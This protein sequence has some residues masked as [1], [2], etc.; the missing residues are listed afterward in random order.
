MA[1]SAGQGQSF[2]LTSFRATR[3]TLALTLESGDISHGAGTRIEH[4]EGGFT[5]SFRA[6][7]GGLTT[8]PRPLTPQE[9]GDLRSALQDELRDPPPDVDAA[10]L[11]AATCLLPEGAGY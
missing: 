5:I 4:G 6:S 2:D 9:A 11:Q 1:D 10:A 7:Q 3:A 8:A